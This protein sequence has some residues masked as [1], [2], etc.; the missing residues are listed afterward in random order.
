M[1]Y[2]VIIGLEV[3]AELRTESKCFCSCRNTYGSTPN[4]NCCPVC[5]GLPGALPVLN[6]KAVEQTIRAGLALNFDINRTAVFERKNYFY[7]DLS[8]AYQISQLEKPICINGHLRVGEKDIPINRIHLEEDAGKLVHQD[9]ITMIDYNRGGVPLIELVTDALVEPHMETADEAIEFL[10]KLRQIYI[11]AG[12]ADCEIE[13]GQMRADVNI[14]LR[15]HG[16]KE[17]G[18]KV[19]MKNIMGFKSVHRAINYEI[20]RQQEILDN[21]GTIEQE[22]RKWDDEKGISFTLRTK[23]NSEDYR[24]FPDPDLLAVNISDEIIDNIRA[25]MPALPDE[26]KK[27]YMEEYG[28]NEYDTNVILADKAVAEFYEECIVKYPQ[29]KTVSNWITTEVLARIKDGGEIQ[30]SVDNLVWIFK[31]V[32]ERKVQRLSAKDLLTNIWGTDLNAEAEAKARGIMADLSNDFVF[33]IVDRILSEKADVVE[34]YK[35]EQDPKILNFLVGQVMR[36]TKGKANAAD[37]MD[38]IKEKIR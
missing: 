24:Y 28:L 17:F 15:P 18:T 3:H 36:E 8:K 38:K 20:A 13:K 29:P 4:S 5:V 2:D 37:V 31:A 25:T 14:S 11:Y 32:D 23:E 7:P 30:I 19:E 21:G 34:Q 12:V 16:S 35:A 26:L 1:K 6:K 9:N 10:T 27:K 33:E 22:T